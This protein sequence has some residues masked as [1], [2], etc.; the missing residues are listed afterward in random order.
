MV[1]YLKIE[2]FTLVPCDEL[3]PDIS[4]YTEPDVI[5]KEILVKKLDFDNHALNSSLDPDEVSRVE[6][7]DES[8]FLI[9]KKPKRVTVD[10]I[11]HFGVSSQ[12]FYLTKQHLLVITDTPLYRQKDSKPYCKISSP[13]DA[14]LDFLYATICHYYEHLR[15]IR[16]ISKDLQSKINSSMG[17]EHL[18]QMF[19]LSESLTYYLDAINAN[20]MVLNKIRNHAVKIAISQD[21]ID[22]LDDLIIDSAQCYK[23]AE[24]YSTIISGLLDA[25]GT[26]VNNNMSK[27]IKNLTVVNIIFL[28]LNLIAGIGGM[29]EY[30]VMTHKIPLWLSY[31]SFFIGMILIAWI[32]LIFIRKYNLGNAASGK[33]RNRNRFS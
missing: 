29:S 13:F 7:E 10:D 17:N 24:I 4:I 28:P 8:L 1:E 33:S 18:I 19:G 21:G 31:C 27:L 32:T 14:M 25:L 23:E 3:A 15:T 12:G 2:K 16:Q 6:F 22:F 9:W 26:L 20:N 30:S 5:E 11:L